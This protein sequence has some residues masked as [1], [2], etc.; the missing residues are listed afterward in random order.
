MTTREAILLGQ[1]LGRLISFGILPH[2]SER[3][4]RAA[5]IQ[6]FGMWPE[7]LRKIFI[8]RRLGLPTE[9]MLAILYPGYARWKLEK[10]EQEALLDLRK[11]LLKGRK[12]LLEAQASYYTQRAKH[13][14]MLIGAQ[15]DYINE[16][17]RLR[18]EALEKENRLREAR[19]L[20][21]IIQ[22][23]NRLTD[24]EMEIV[25]SIGYASKPQ[26]YQPILDYIRKQKEVVFKVL[27]PAIPKEKRK[28]ILNKIVKTHFPPP[29]DKDKEKEEGESWEERA[30]RWRKEVEE[31]AGRIWSILKGELGRIPT[32]IKEGIPKTY[33]TPEPEVLTPYES[34]ERLLSPQ[35]TISPIMPIEE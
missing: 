16:I 15:K 12:N 6:A 31:A 18:K 8:A 5:R 9:E 34:Y 21:E 23:F 32:I 30:R 25:T 11:D 35:I 22:E 29:T 17:W 10:E 19:A 14:Q 20:S 2:F 26:V 4:K 27:E 28:D 33:E 1:E 13:Q 7:E 3:F 24:Y